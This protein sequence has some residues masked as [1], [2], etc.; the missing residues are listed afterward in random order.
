MES[1]VEMLR[2]GVAVVKP[3]GRLDLLTASDAKVEFQTLVA[4]GHERL[5]VDLS[6]VDSMDSSG[7]GALISGLKAAR[8]ASGDLRIACANPSVLMV[9]ELTRLDQVLHPYPSLGLA[10]ADY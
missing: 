7:L 9:L 6:Q 2:P 3:T 8:L 5:V 10:L 1:T 4:S